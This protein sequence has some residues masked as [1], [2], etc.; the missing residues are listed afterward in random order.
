[1]DMKSTEP[2]LVISDLQMVE[3]LY[4]TKNM[5]FDK[6]DKFKNIT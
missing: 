3:D 1:M 5:Y 2:T 6:N 4:F